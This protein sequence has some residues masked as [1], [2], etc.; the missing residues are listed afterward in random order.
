MNEDDC[1]PLLLSQ[2]ER[3]ALEL[4]IQRAVSTAE[5]ADFPNPHDLSEGAFLAGFPDLPETIPV[6]LDE[7]PPAA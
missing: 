3:S 4:G 7:S 2:R 1:F 5:V 6:A